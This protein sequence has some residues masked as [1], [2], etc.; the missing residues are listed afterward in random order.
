M[1]DELL[2]YHQTPE[3]EPFVVD[4]M[5]NVE[6]Q[7]KTRKLILA[8]SG[9]IGGLFGVAGAMMLSDPI[10]HLIVQISSEGTAMPF[11]LA[12]ISVVA[13]L[14]WLLQDDIRMRV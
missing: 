12:T 10:A 7:H 4:V 3:T 5:K 13:F 2:Q 14:G 1:L 6:R 9:L 11:G 8:G